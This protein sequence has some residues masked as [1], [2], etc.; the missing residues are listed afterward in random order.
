MDALVFKV[1]HNGKIEKRAIFR[2]LG[3]DKDGM[4]D[5]LG[6]YIA[7][8]EG[9]KFWLSILT[10]LQNRGVEDILIACIDNLVGFGDAI[11]SIF[12]D[13]EVQLC[14]VHQIRNSL[15]YVI[16]EDEKSFSRDLKKVYQAKE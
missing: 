14:I 3:I 1:R 10:D 13:T 4:K 6:I 7:E 11:E 12:P 2:V 16:S 9:A 15:K 5:L 8:N